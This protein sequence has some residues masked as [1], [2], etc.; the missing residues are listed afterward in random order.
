MQKMINFK[1]RNFW[2]NE[3][4]LQKLNEKLLSLNSIGWKALSFTV[5]SNFLGIILSYSILLEKVE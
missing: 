3:P 4:N 2:T 1:I 5:N